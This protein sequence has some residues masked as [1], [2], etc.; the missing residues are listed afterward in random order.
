MNERDANLLLYIRDE[1]EILLEMID[2]YDFHDFL[3]DEVMKR[4]VSMTLI[5]IGES[6]KKLSE[7][8]KR[9]KREI[10]WREIADLRNMAAH[11]YDGLHMG[12]VF[13]NVTEDIPKLLEQVKGI[14][15]DEGIEY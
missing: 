6:V 14:L 2:G 5:N 10:E 9:E 1:A 13:G 12:W 8:F 15:K 4:A 11:N 3:S 7:G